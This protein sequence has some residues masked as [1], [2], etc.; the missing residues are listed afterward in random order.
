MLDCLFETREV[1]R[2]FPAIS[3]HE[4][5][6]TECTFN[7]IPEEQENI[8]KKCLNDET[9]SDIIVELTG[10]NWNYTSTDVNILYTDFMNIIQTAIDKVT[11]NENYKHKQKKIPLD[12][13]IS[14]TGPTYERQ[15]V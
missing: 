4:I 3:D 7:N 2:D 6:G 15:N 12:N 10:A 11:P 14:T 9:I 13:S 5:I 8:H 1:P